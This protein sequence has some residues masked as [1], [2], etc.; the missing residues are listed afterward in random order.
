MRINNFKLRPETGRINRFCLFAEN[1]KFLIIK[2]SF[3]FTANHPHNASERQRKTIE[4]IKVNSMKIKQTIIYSINLFRTYNNHDRS[5]DNSQT[6]QYSCRITLTA[7][8]L[9]NRMEFRHRELQ[10]KKNFPPLNTK[11]QNVVFLP[12][13]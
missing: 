9:N 4:H 6:A 1:K 13:K 2:K 3:D 8:I 5:S 11:F 7:A 12:S 10:H